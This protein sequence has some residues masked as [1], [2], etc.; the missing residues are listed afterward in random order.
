MR[1]RY[2]M[3]ALQL[4]LTLTLT[5]ACGT[6]IAADNA[7]GAGAATGA[8]ANT[9]TGGWRQAR[10]PQTADNQ[11]GSATSSSPRAGDVPATQVQGTLPSPDINT[12]LVQEAARLD[13]E[14]SP[15]EIRS[16]RGIMSENERAIS[17]PVTSVVPRISTLTVSLSPGASLP[18]V[19]TA[20]NNLSVVTFTD[21][22]GTPWPQSDPPYNPAPRLFDVQYNAN[23]VTI[24][25]LR[26]WVSGNVS[27]YLK[28]LS[29]PVI[30]NVTSGE[31]DT[32]TTS[33]EMDSRLDLRIPREGPGSSVLAT[34]EDKIALHDRTLQAFLDGVPPDDPS[35]RR[36]KFTGN[37]PDTTIWQ[38]GD[39]LL[40]RSRAVL[41]DE[42]EQTL[43]SADGTHLWK[44][45]VTPLLTFSVDGRS[46]HVTPD[47][48]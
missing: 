2:I 21:I 39:E 47:L 3:S 23:M 32:R 36:L 7:S 40:V 28:G 19:R 9:G 41:R 37:V 17:A 30:L 45:P 46:V 10:V 6:A 43:S 5:L 13:S 38:S 18:L 34:P 14:L 35:V 27:V 12:P 26:P 1:T 4:A 22:N 29:V 42:F 11:S 20:M 8:G 24:T 44:L 25:P 48:E 33:Q 31:T 15:D 16:L